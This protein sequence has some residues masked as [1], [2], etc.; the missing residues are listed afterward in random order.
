MAQVKVT[1]VKS[2]IGRPAAQIRTMEALGLGKIDRVKVH[3]V[4]PSI[5]GMI[6]QVSHLVKVEEA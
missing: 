5:L 3:Q 6:K 2:T 4:T 1:Q